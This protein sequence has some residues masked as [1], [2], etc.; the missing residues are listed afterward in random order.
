MCPLSRTQENTASSLSGM[1]RKF[2]SLLGAEDYFEKDPL[3][4]KEKRKVEY[5][6]VNL[7]VFFC[8]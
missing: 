6:I 5:S 3:E 7:F 8:D 1:E 4:N 2:S